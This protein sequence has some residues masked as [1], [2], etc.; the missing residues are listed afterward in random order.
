MERPKLELE[1][2]RPSKIRLMF[3]DAI[4]GE[5][6]Y[7]KYYLYAVTNGNDNEYSFFAPEEVHNVL[8]DHNKGSEFLITKLVSQGKGKKLNTVWEVQIV[9]D[10]GKNNAINSSKTAPTNSYLDS[11]LQ[12]FADAI[13]V[14]ERYNGANPNQLAITMFIQRTKNNGF[15]DQQ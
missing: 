12:S 14:Q 13:K 4:T 9:G 11:M 3:D 5:S 8:K 2:N 6:Q 7:G 15:S 1:I 10:D